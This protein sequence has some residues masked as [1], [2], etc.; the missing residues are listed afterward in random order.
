MSRIDSPAADATPH[1]SPEAILAHPRF[2]EARC[3]TSKAFWDCT[4][5]IP[6]H[7]PL[8]GG[9]RRRLPSRQIDAAADLDRLS[10]DVA[11]PCSAQ[12]RHHPGDVL[13]RAFAA[14][15]RVTAA[16]NRAARA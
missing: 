8:C 4:S 9:I 3:A 2:P 10:G 14:N 5:T 11:A 1:H 16:R 6:S 7:A 15:Q 12:Q 13:R